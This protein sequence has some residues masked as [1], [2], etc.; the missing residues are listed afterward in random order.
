[1]RCLK[2]KDYVWLF[3]IYLVMVLCICALIALA[4]YLLI[5]FSGGNDNNH[6]VGMKIMYNAKSFTEFDI[7]DRQLINELDITTFIVVWSDDLDV[8]L[9]NF[10]TLTFIIAM[11]QHL[12]KIPQ[13]I[14]FAKSH[15]QVVGYYTFDEPALHNI[16]AVYQEYI[17]NYIRN[18]DNNTVVRPVYVAQTAWSLSVDD[19][20]KG[21]SLNAFDILLVDH[22]TSDISTLTEMYSNFDYLSAFSKEFILVLPAYNTKICRAT[23]LNVYKA[24]KEVFRFLD[25]DEFLNRN[26][27]SFYLFAYD[28]NEGYAINNCKEIYNE[29]RQISFPLAL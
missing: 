28:N 13:I 4:I 19:L 24:T 2:K 29:V 18:L 27:I 9:T 25:L 10:A 12:S 3:L 22:Y 14:E 5:I 21:F 23:T 7:V 1:M 8:I 15:E 17:Y 6:V 26:I 11:Q 16:T 20:S